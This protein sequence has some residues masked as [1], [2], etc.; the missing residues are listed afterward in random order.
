M[1]LFQFSETKHESLQST[2]IK[3]RSHCFKK[4]LPFRR[5]P[6]GTVKPLSNP[7]YALI[8]PAGFDRVTFSYLT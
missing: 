6:E 4:I 8:S 2:K 1:D 5:N 3:K 7:L